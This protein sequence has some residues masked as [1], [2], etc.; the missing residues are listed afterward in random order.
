[1]IGRNYYI[2]ILL[3]GILIILSC[4]QADDVPP[5][6]TLNGNDSVNQILNSPYTDQ[7]ATAIDE[8][9]G[10]ITKNI[11]VDNTVNVNKVGEYTVTYHV[12]DKAG[13]EANPLIRKV[14]VYNQSDVYAGYYY[15]TETQKYPE[16]I[17]CEYQISVLYDSTVNNRLVFDDFACNFGKQVYS[18]VENSALIMPYQVVSDTLISLVLQGSGSINDTSMILDYTI[19]SDTINSLWQ[20][21]MKRLK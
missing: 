7:G 5:I 1:M 9:D 21:E 16:S 18:D 15:L 4:Q 20:A 17:F 10:T 14:N 3:V 12:I 19:Q 13:N 6:L 8:T 11:F 2:L